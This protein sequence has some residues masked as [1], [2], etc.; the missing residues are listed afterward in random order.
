M[1]C[2]LYENVQISLIGTKDKG[3]LLVIFAVGARESPV[4]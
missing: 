4:D 3:G 1:L 2:V